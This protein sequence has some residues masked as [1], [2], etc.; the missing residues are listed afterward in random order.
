MRKFFVA[1]AVVL[2]CGGAAFAQPAASEWA[3]FG[4]PGNAAHITRTVR[5]A[6]GEMYFDPDEL[7]AKVGDTIEFV[8]TNKGRKAHEF[9]IG[10]E[11]FQLQHMKEM[12]AMPGMEMDEPNELQLKPG[13]SK[14]VVWHFTK[15]GDFLYAC[16]IP[17]HA[18]AG[19]EGDLHVK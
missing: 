6:A 9:V 8:V 15:A 17:G 2:L 10:D 13:E 19:M 7:A 14:S 4:E 18:D 12:Q 11:P 5:I 1:S 3:A 16:D